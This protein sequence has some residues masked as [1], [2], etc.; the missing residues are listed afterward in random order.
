[1]Y[2]EKSE[3]STTIVYFIEL[4]TNSSGVARRVNKEVEWMRWSGGK[5]QIIV[6]H[7]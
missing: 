7:L 1:L 6:D 4:P 3:N 5:D 2:E